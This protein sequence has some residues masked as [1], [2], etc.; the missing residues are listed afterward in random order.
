MIYEV[1]LPDGR[2]IEVEGEPGQEEKAF[3]TVK[4]YLAQEAGGKALNETEFDYETGIQ[5]AS[6]RAQLDTADS[7]IE[8]ESVLQGFVGSDGFIRDANGRL[9]NKWDRCY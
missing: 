2:I 7:I 6:L 4:Q 3:K 8:K 9:L 5:N 1:E